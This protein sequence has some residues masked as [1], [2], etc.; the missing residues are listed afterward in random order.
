MKTSRRITI[1]FVALVA[2]VAAARS[3][4]SAVFFLALVG[5]I[6]ACGF[7]G[8]ARRPSAISLR[9]HLLY[10]ALALLL[11]AGIALY[12]IYGRG[13]D[14]D[15]DFNNRWV[16]ICLTAAS[17]FGFAAKEFWESRKQW[18]FWATFSALFSAHIVILSH[19][20]APAEQVPFL[21]FAPIA[22]AEIFVVF[23]ILGTLG[24]PSKH[25]SSRRTL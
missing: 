11:V 19:V 17:V 7:A 24:F 13:R 25:M 8:G 9:D 21:L 12:A 1:P 3:D 23:M 22:I 4:N 20:F 10:V 6:F 18:R 14:I 2:L 5:F 16:V 15:A